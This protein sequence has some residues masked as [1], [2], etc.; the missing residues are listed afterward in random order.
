MIHAAQAVLMLA[1]APLIQGVMAT[2]RA[3]SNGRPGPSVLQP[4]RNLRK[5]LNK[6]AVVALKTSPLAL[7]APGLSVGVAATL[8]LLVPGFFPT[9][10]IAP[11]AVAIALTLSLGRFVLVL[12]ALD[13]RSSFEGMAASREAT[14]AVLTEAP[15]ILALISIDAGVQSPIPRMLAGIALVLVSLYETARIPVDNQE[16]HY[17]L[18]MIHEGLILEYSGW[19]L[20]LLQ[21]ASHLRQLALLLL[22]AM[23]LPGPAPLAWLAFILLAIPLIERFVA[24]MRLFEVPAIFAT[25]TIL[26]LTALVIRIGGS[27]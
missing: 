5:L 23:L 25:A 14:F 3:R 10:E 20:G 18:T 19:H 21:Y 22:A 8:V 16:T 17:E 7:A 12:A 6:E 2:I 24:K 26:A 27:A 4:Y 1:L 15:L 13:T 9:P 11:D